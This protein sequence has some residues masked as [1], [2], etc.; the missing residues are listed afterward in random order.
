MTSDPQPNDEPLLAEMSNLSANLF[1]EER[2][3]AE[4]TLAQAEQVARLSP[5]E[6]EN[7]IDFCLDHEYVAAHILEMAPWEFKNAKVDARSRAAE[8]YLEAGSWFIE[9]HD[10][11][12]AARYLRIAVRLAWHSPGDEYRNIEVEAARKIAYC[13]LTVSELASSN[14]SK[15]E[16]YPIFQNKAASYFELQA[17]LEKR[18]GNLAHAADAFSN[19]AHRFHRADNY[20]R[21]ASSALAEAEIRE[22]LR[23]MEGAANASSKEADAWRS[24]ANQDDWTLEAAISAKIRSGWLLAG[25]DNKKQ[26]AAREFAEAGIWA[27]KD[28]TKRMPEL[29]D[30][31]RK[32]AK[33]YDE[34]GEY[35]EADQCHINLRRY[36]RKVRGLLPRRWLSLQYVV[37]WLLEYTWGYGARPR[38]LV[39]AALVVLI[40]FSLLFFAVHDVEWANGMRGRQISVA[41]RA[42]ACLALSFASFIP[43]EALLRIANLH[44]LPALAAI[45]VGPVSLV[46]AFAE[47]LIGATLI[48]MAGMAVTRWLKRHFLYPSD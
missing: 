16:F 15:Q 31:L 42:E 29:A 27:L 13:F 36:E 30:A 45:T 39:R 4:T 12:K 9:S 23:D 33:I 40:L 3:Q 43:A 11:D 46:V 19:A 5:E 17:T 7:A 32:A 47:S 1:V 41:K 25:D 18:R 24:V 44:I 28:G 37:S 14:K 6:V 48:A 34:L 22:T 10:Y 2:Q 21:S 8:A 35:G 20:R 26:K 38:R